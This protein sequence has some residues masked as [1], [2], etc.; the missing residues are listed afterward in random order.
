M[1]CHN[2]FSSWIIVCTKN[3]YYVAFMKNIH[4]PIIFYLFILIYEF[5]Y[6]NTYNDIFVQIY[7]VR[8]YFIKKYSMVHLYFYIFL[9]RQ[10]IYCIFLFESIFMKTLIDVHKFKSKELTLID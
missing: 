8:I 4:A 3:K 5:L 1:F 7:I 2:Y 9:F 10:I 6:L